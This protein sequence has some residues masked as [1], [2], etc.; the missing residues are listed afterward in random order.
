MIQ[1]LS[2]RALFEGASEGLRKLAADPRSRRA[3]AT[4]GPQL[5]ELFSP[6]ARRYVLAPQRAELL[7]RID[8]LRDKGYEVS[9][10][11][12]AAGDEDDD[13][14]RIERIVAEYLALLTY[15][16]APDRL[17]FDLSQVGLAISRQLALQN[18]GRIAAAAAA[19]GSDIILDMGQHST[20]DDVLAVHQ[21]LAEGFDNVGITL[22]AQLHRTESDAAAVAQRGRRIRLV[23]GACQEPSD[24]ALSRGPALDDRFLGLAEQLVDHGVRLSLATQDREVLI[25]A[26]KSGILPRVAELEMRHGVQPQLLR[27]YR[28]TG[29]PCRI[30]ATYGPN[31][32]HL[33][34]RLV[35]HPSMVLSAL[36][37][38]GTGRAYAAAAGY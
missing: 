25:A 34:Q 5:L 3:F 36:A 24:N 29:L 20:V 4:P 15:E 31:W 16:R 19:R 11:F 6:A 18:T 17:S 21:E 26:D 35:E 38:I 14:A 7:G 8:A 22:Q 1:E 28:A 12:S 33:L 27:R 13:P 2:Q 9:V 23:K 32:L 10:E 37:D 30:H